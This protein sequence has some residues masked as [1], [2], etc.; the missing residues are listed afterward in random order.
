MTQIASS[1]GQVLVFFRLK[2]VLTSILTIQV[3]LATF[4]VRAAEGQAPKPGPQLTELKQDYT[5]TDE[6]GQTKTV[7]VEV[8]ATEVSSPEEAETAK[9]WFRREQEKSPAAEHYALVADGQEPSQDGIELKN[10][11]K[12]KIPK[13]GFEQLGQWLTDSKSDNAEIQAK[14]DSAA[15]RFF[16]LVSHLAS[17]R[18]S[19][20]MVRFIIVGGAMYT[21]FVYSKLPLWPSAVAAGTLGLISGA[22]QLNVK[23]YT[24]FLT[25][26]GAV[27]NIPQTLISRVAQVFGF[28]YM[29]TR[30]R[31]SRS[32]P[33]NFV[34]NQSVKL[35]VVSSAILAIA[36]LEFFLMDA[37]LHHSYGE[38]VSSILMTA[39]LNISGQGTF[40]TA[41]ATHKD[42]L[43]KQLDDPSKLKRVEVTTAIKVVSV[44]LVSNLATSMIATGS[45]TTEYI[46]RDILYAL[47]AG[48]I[49]YW[50]YLL[51]KYDP[52][53]RGIFK[54]LKTKCTNWL[55]GS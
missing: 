24:N 16:H 42:E 34:F 15:N 45:A 51:F 23:E 13:E 25:R 32:L 55:S 18:Y 41:V 10:A 44:A 27:V 8:T 35:F 4:P 6:N 53:V 47:T 37:P 40:D 2:R 29:K 7:E 52:Y 36:N 9:E 46:G 28:N 43:K 38:T 20:A 48:G 50:S 49:A 54:S 5:F 17:N 22:I 30:E 11:E 26:H 3:S 1:G 14:R 12:I 19:L 21:G 33:F 31:L 39:F